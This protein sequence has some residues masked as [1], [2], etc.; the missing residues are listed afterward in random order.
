LV[1]R[2]N[3][4]RLHHR[5]QFCSRFELQSRGFCELNVSTEIVCIENSLDVLQRV[6][7]DGSDLSFALGGSRRT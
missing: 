5:L 3:E 1:E 6:T 2:Q 4:R 7:G